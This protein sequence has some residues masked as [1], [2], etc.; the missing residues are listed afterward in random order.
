VKKLEAELA[1]LDAKNG[2]KGGKDKEEAT[3]RAAEEATEQ[4]DSAATSSPTTIAEAAAAAGATVE[5]LCEY[6]RDDLVEMLTELGIGV[7]N[8][9]R[10][11]KEVEARRQALQEE[12]KMAMQQATAAA[13]RPP[14]NQAQEM[15]E[16]RRRQMQQQ[17]GYGGDPRASSGQGG[18]GGAGGGASE[19]PAGK[20]TVKR[21]YHCCELTCCLTGMFVT[22]ASAVL[23]VAMLLMA[24]SDVTEHTNT[25][26][27]LLL[28][29]FFATLGGGSCVFCM[30]YLSPRYKNSEA[31]G[32]RKLLVK[33][34]SIMALQASDNWVWS[35][36]LRVGY[37]KWPY[38]FSMAMFMVSLKFTQLFALTY[39][40]NA[41]QR[42]HLPKLYLQIGDVVLLDIEELVQED[43]S[44][45]NSGLTAAF[46]YAQSAN[47]SAGD[48][49]INTAAAAAATQR[50][51]QQALEFTAGEGAWD[52]MFGVFVGTCV[53]VLVMI[54][55]GK[56][57]G[58]FTQG[59]GRTGGLGK[60]ITG[61]LKFVTSALFI[62]MYNHLIQALDCTYY[63]RFNITSGELETGLMW[64][65]MQDM[66]GAVET[67]CYEGRHMAILLFAMLAICFFQWPVSFFLCTLPDS[68]P[69]PIRDVI[70]DEFAVHQKLTGRLKKVRNYETGFEWRL[71]DVPDRRKIDALKR[72]ELRK[73]AR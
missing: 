44:T 15:Q 13:R 60:V 68:P 5:E 42:E 1:A 19:Q 24:T 55:G 4:A 7:V 54:C 46:E 71:G 21:G 65:T 8:R 25:N 56:L 58:C 62:P 48:R 26:H 39:D 17:A 28:T 20:E 14:M 22:L 32:G 66:E 11:L 36:S 6:T 70:I 49:Q 33:S 34:K 16:R 18:D 37:V 47:I 10:M 45:F 59:N 38:V 73:Q 69:D 64:D 43:N 57:C 72:S 23:L 12:Q 3:P 53:V 61:L 30:L 63:E 9:N 52:R 67:E 35:M 40:E 51:V 27:L 50:K 41:I 29:G 2:S 31:N